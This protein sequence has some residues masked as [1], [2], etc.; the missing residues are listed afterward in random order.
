MD[1]QTGG[2]LDPPMRL[3]VSASAFP[4][5]ERVDAWRETFGRHVL[6]LE[7]APLDDTPFRYDA[8]FVGLPDLHLGLGTVSAIACNRTRALLADEKDD[9][10][11][12]IPREGRMQ[13]DQG[14]KQGVLTHGDALVRRSDALGRTMSTSGEYLTLVIPEKALSPLVADFDRLDFTVI[15]GANPALRLLSGYVDLLMTQD[16]GTGSGVGTATADL[17]ARHVH[18]LAALAIGATRDGW[19]LAQ[20]EGHG[21]R[22]ARLRAVRA[23]IAR[24]AVDGDYSIIRAAGH[25]GISPAYVRKLLAAEGTRFSD[26]VLEERLQRARRLLADPRHDRLGIA[27][28]AFDSGFGDVSYFNRCFRRRFGATPSDLRAR[29]REGG[30]R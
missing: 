14:R 15:P 26:L 25:L 23:D 22:A 16:P 27:G 12:L 21:L 7:I 6:R 13:V 24:H 4:E 28:I 1:D 17:A 19:A 5:R 2:G 20:A 29:M 10:L 8:E 18:E 9:I 3:R 11:L 30:A